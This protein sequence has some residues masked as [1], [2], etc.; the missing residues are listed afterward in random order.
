MSAGHHVRLSSKDD[1]QYVGANG[2]FAAL[3]ASV[4]PWSE[5]ACKRETTSSVSSVKCNPLNQ[6]ELA[7]LEP[8][9]LASV[10]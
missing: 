10:Q 7:Y 9:G 1:K 5:A 3:C 6:E 8:A 2:D 4:R